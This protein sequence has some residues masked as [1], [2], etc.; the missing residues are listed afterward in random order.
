[1][2]EW[3]TGLS[4]PERAAKNVENLINLRKG[5]LPFDRGL[6]VNPDYIDKPIL[7]L[8][9]EIITEL[10]DMINEREPRVQVSLEQADVLNSESILEVTIG[11]A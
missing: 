11:D 7:E 5:D 4:E 10:E 3:S 9:S 6:G 8:S 1:M 2:F